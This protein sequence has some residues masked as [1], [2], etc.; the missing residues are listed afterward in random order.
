MIAMHLMIACYT[1]NLQRLSN[2][3]KQFY[4]PKFNV[5]NNRQTYRKK[6]VTKSLQDKHQ[7]IITTVHPWCGGH[8]TNINA[9][10]VS[11]QGQGLSLQEE[12]LHTYILRLG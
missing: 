5:G 6:W 10:G 3:N 7:Q 9:C 2:L 4:S 8:S 11:G 12:A 1:F